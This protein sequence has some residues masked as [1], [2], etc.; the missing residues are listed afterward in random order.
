MCPL[1]LNLYKLLTTLYYFSTI[2]SS[3]FKHAL[4]REIGKWNTWTQPYRLRSPD[5]GHCR[6]IPVAGIRS[7]PARIRSIRSIR[8]PESGRRNSVAGHRNLDS[9]T[10]IRNPVTGITW[11]LINMCFYWPYEIL[12][13]PSKPNTMNYWPPINM[14]QAL[15]MFTDP[16]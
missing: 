9:V 11:H 13:T 12:L 8:S 2:L 1:H 4:E 5:S 14:L 6:R 3:Y 15:K 7:Q 10:G 16:Q